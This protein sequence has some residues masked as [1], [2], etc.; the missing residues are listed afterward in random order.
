MLATPF[1]AWLAMRV[2]SGP[3]ASA[4]GALRGGSGAAAGTAIGSARDS[5]AVRI[6]PVTT[7]PATKPAAIRTSETK[8]RRTIYGYADEGSDRKDTG[9]RHRLTRRRRAAPRERS[10]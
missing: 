4:A 10:L 3:A 2:K 7:R 5:E 6:R 1:T 9:K 8:N